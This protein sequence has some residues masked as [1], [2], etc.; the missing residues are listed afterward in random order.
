M[1]GSDGV[2]YE[3]KA[4]KSDLK[5]HANYDIN[6][7]TAGSEQTMQGIDKKN[8]LTFLQSNKINPL[9]NPKVMAEMEATIA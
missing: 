1:I 7:I 9:Y 4:T 2:Q 3:K 8:K 6:I 5:R